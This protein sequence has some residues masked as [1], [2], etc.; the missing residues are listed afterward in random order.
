MNHDGK[1]RKSEWDGGKRLKQGAGLEVNAM[2]DA[3][4]ALLR[5]LSVR[6]R[7]HTGT[8]KENTRSRDARR[9]ANQSGAKHE[10]KRRWIHEWGSA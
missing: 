5:Q 10:R 3:F 7:T 1:R 6:P 8:S 9:A 4:G 2:L